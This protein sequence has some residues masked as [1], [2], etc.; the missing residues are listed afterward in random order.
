MRRTD[1]EITDRAEM[2]AV[3]KRAQICHVG[4]CDGD[5]PYIVPVNFGY[6]DNIVYFHCAREGRKLD[7]IRKNPNVCVQFDADREMVVDDVACEWSFKY[8]S[9]IAFG[10]AAIIDDREEKKRALDIIM[11]QYSAKEFV[12][13]DN[14]VDGI[15]IVKIEIE[16]MTGKRSG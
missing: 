16:R 1:R 2:E 14:R 13:K 4:L 11:A 8:E 3:I 6:R 15:Y 5:E 10:K 12:Y 9:V 7:I